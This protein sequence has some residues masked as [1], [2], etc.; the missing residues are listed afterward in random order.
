MIR[1]QPAQSFRS[2]PTDSGRICAMTSSVRR[3]AARSSAVWVGVTRGRLRGD[4]A[5]ASSGNSRSCATS[6]SRLTSAPPRLFRQSLDDA[7]KVSREFG[8]LRGGRFAA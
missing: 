8:F 1:P 5:G 6:A 2:L 3:K 4:R 7:E